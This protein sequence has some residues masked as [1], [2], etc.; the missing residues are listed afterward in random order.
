MIGIVESKIAYDSTP[1]ITCSTTPRFTPV[2]G[3]PHQKKDASSI[4]SIMV[5]QHNVQKLRQEG[6]ITLARRSIQNNQISSV[7]RAAVLYDVP[8]T[9]LVRRVN[10]IVPL[11]EFNAKKRKLQPSEE[12]ALVEWALELNRRG[13]P[14]Y[15]ID[16]R[17]MA[18]TLL[19]ARGQNPPPQPVGKNWV[20]RFINA[21][22]ELQTKW[23]R[24]FHS[25]R[26][27]CEDPKI[28]EPWFRLV[29]ETRQAH[30]IL[31]EDTYNFDETGFAMGIAATSK[32]VTSS[33]II[34]RAVTV[35]PG[36][37][38][39]V[40]A[41]EGIN[42]TGWVIPPF[43]ILSGKLHQAGWYQAL[44]TDWVLAVSDNGW[45]TDELGYAWIQHFNRC[46]QSR[47]KGAYRL[48][49]LDGHGSHATPEFDQFCTENKIITHCMPAHTSHLLQPLNVS[50]YSPLKL[51]YGQEVLNLARQGIHHIDKEEFLYIYKKVRLSVF[52]NQNI[53]SG[54]LATGL[55]PYDP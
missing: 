40:T 18:D 26:A 41:I 44:P 38:K 17:R 8:Q 25:Q 34:G 29:E 11:T 9:S 42:A 16:L 24:K 1:T 19:T 35:Q 23:N 48:L 31:D 10:G 49:I 53:R 43:V 51:A 3:S 2:L 6:R 50:C 33:D 45:T 13:F 46:T 30:G 5:S 21:Q 47:T 22:P 54:F 20:S 52:S 14:P 36:N 32:V 7:R 27:K 12:Q 39:W 37:R 4:K 55:L 28:I 15:I